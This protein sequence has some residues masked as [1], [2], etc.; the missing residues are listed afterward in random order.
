MKNI[1]FAVTIK[2]DEKYYSYV[3]KTTE[4]DNIL[5]KLNIK[6]IISANILPKNEAKRTAEYWNECHKNNGTYMFAEPLF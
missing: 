2:E 3:V 5:S 1:Y 6:N 4:S